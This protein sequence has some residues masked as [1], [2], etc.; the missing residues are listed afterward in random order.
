M[1]NTSSGMTAAIVAVALIIGVAGGYLYGQKV[2]VKLGLAQAESAVKQK[3]EEAAKAAENLAAQA[4]NPFAG[5]Q[6]PLENVTTNPFAKVKVNPF[7]Q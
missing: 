1:D 6:N 2:G 5:T 4:A 7:A 3:S